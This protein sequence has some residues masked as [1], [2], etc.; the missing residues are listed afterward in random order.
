MA[1]MQ[2]VRMITKVPTDVEGVRALLIKLGPALESRQPGITAQ[3]QY[4]NMDQPLMLQGKGGEVATVRFERADAE[5]AIKVEVKPPDRPL[6]RIRSSWWRWRTRWLVKLAL[7]RAK[8]EVERAYPKALVDAS[9]AITP[10]VLP[11]Q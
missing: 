11:P 6:G 5:T 9:G 7:K 1:V 4:L 10:E 3:L 8:L 2:P